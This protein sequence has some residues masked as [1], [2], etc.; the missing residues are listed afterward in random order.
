MPPGSCLIFCPVFRQGWNTT[1]SLVVRL[2]KSFPPL[3]ALDQSC[4]TVLETT[5]GH[6]VAGVPVM[7][8]TFFPNLLAWIA[9]GSSH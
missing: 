1:I 6:N 9:D 3:F 4:N 7:E 2:N 8:A 5:P